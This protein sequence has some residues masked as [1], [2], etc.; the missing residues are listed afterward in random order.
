MTYHSKKF[1]TVE[2]QGG[3]I[4]LISP[5]TH[6]NVE[7]PSAITSS[8]NLTVDVSVNIEWDQRINT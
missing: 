2:S 7:V 5:N 1:T 8:N 6:I 3:E 4:R